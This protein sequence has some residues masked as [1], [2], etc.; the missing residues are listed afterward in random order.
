MAAI[1]NTLAPQTANPL[2]VDQ[3]PRG[4]HDGSPRSGGGGQGGDKRGTS[5]PDPGAGSGDTVGLLP[6]ITPLHTSNPMFRPTTLAESSGATTGARGHAHRRGRGRGRGAGRRISFAPKHTRMPAAAATTTVGGS[7]GARH[8]G[9]HGGAVPSAG[10]ELAAV[11]PHV[12]AP[13]GHTSDAGSVPVAAR[14]N[15]LPA[16]ESVA[17]GGDVTPAHEAAVPNAGAAQQR[18]P[19]LASVASWR[20]R[21]DRSR[22][23]PKRGGR[24]GKSTGKGALWR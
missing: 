18:P 14:V 4:R 22:P 6:G 8:D 16:L 3:T 5:T 17:A 7:G 9:K 15:R 12:V 2:Y 20:P 13:M 23:R 21:R 11:T 24:G 19:A 10:I 1:V